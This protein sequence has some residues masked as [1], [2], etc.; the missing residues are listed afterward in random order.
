MMN[1]EP[2]L[3]PEFEKLPAGLRFHTD[4]DWLDSRHSF[5][6]GE[7]YDPQRLGFRTLRVI[8][9]DRVKPG[10]GFPTH[11]H[12]DMEIISYV[13]NGELA[14][15][16][17][18]GNGSVIRRGDVQRMTAGT[19]VTHSEMNPSPTEPVRFL[20]IWILPA[21]Q[22]LTPSYEQIL[23][24]DE[25]KR[26]RFRVIASPDGRDGSVIV[27]QDSTLLASILDPKKTATYEFA[28]D[29]YGWLQVVTGKLEVHGHTLEEGDGLAMMNVTSLSVLATVPSEVILFDLA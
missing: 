2:A 14:H 24:A 10:I 12:R 13:V 23:I 20:Q 5:S 3:T 6:F 17:S 21:E 1:V 7:H 28:K 27:H 18:L 15:K 25:E 16:D 9:D 22:N 8:N 29:R 11:S 4:I 26:N 19:K